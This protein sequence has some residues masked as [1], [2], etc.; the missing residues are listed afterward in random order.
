MSIE[1]KHGSD[2]AVCF[3]QQT[4]IAIAQIEAQEKQLKATHPISFEY[5]R[6]GQSISC[7]EY[8]KAVDKSYAA[9]QPSAKVTGLDEQCASVN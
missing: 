2:F 4:D 7:Q 3:K 9:S 1:Q 8:W 5:T 6:D